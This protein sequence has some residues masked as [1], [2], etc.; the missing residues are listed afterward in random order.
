M[1]FFIQD[2][3]VVKEGIGLGVVEVVV[4]FKTEDMEDISRYS[5]FIF[6]Y[7]NLAMN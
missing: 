1:V 4:D 5:I 2:Q 7:F 3:N 6:V